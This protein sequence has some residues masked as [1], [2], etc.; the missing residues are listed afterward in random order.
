MKLRIQYSGPLRAAVG[1]AEEELDVTEDAML[2]DVLRELASRR[3]EG[4]AAHLATASGQAPSGLLVVVNGSAIA[5]SQIHQIPMRC[6]DVI[7]LLPPI[8]GG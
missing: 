3:G 6:G 8:A 1:R 7:A 5:S 2:A 4:A